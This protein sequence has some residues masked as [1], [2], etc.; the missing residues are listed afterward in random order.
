MQEEVKKRDLPKL[1]RRLVAKLTPG[2]ILALS[3][4]LGSGKTTLV[5][6]I[7]RAM[8]YRGQVTSPTFVIERRYPIKYKKINLIYHLDFYRLTSRDLVTID[9]LDY[10][11]DQDSLTVIEWPEIA[12]AYLPPQ[13][14]RIQLEI[15]NEQTRRYLLGP[16]LGD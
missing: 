12:A 5:Q 1:A 16:N 11:G 14:K 10:L 15:V 8:G 7:A 9:W 13:T 6:A 4:L 2:D 3:G